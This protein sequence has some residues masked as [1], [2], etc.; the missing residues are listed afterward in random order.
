MALELNGKKRGISQKDFLAFAASLGVSPQKAVSRM[1]RYAKV[2]SRLADVVDRGFLDKS[3][4]NVLKKTIA[5]R[6]RLLGVK[7]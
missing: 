6:L 2:F 3:S 7:V 1:K 5:T 4:K